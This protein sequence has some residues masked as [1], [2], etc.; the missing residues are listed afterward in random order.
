MPT[1]GLAPIPEIGTDP[2]PGIEVEINFDGLTP[3]NQVL[4][5][6]F[7]LTF[8]E[9]EDAE[10]A[11]ADPA[12]R[13]LRDIVQGNEWRLRRL[14]GKAFI[15]TASG[16]QGATVSPAYQVALGFIVCN[17]YDDGAPLTD[18][19]EVNPLS[20]DSM[21]DP[22]IWRRTWVLH[23]YGVI[24]SRA[25]TNQATID[26]R[27]TPNMW[28]FPTSNIEYGSVHDGPHIDAKTARVI[29]RSERLFGVLAARRYF[30]DGQTT[31]QDGNVRML[32]DYRLLGSLRGQAYGN[33][34]NT[35]R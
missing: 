10:T 17:T 32:L 8:D 24:G 16:V 35:S 33:R 15:S 14:V 21:E 7:P 13:T 1:F 4:W 2:A 6:A 12:K 22:W 28:G 34:G 11:Q 9:T 26:T 3:E 31:F 23:P 20:Q 29:H 30:V 25:F 27:N 18:F 19:E 5:D